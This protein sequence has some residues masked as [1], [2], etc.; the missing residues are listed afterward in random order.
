[1]FIL[2]VEQF[3][4]ESLGEDVIG[5]GLNTMGKGPIV[6]YQNIVNYDNQIYLGNGENAPAQ[7]AYG[8]ATGF[9]TL[10]SCPTV[11]ATSISPTYNSV[12]YAFN[13]YYFCEFWNV[14]QP[15]TNRM[16]IT[17]DFN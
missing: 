5:D 3:K 8:T 1:M 7:A 16:T 6:S 17:E 12:G 9:N 15:Q 14:I 10:G 11:V 4:G 13:C 2:N